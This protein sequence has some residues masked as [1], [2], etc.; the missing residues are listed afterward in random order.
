MH[1]NNYLFEI[2]NLPSSVSVE[3]KHLRLFRYR[4]AAC[5]FSNLGAILL[6]IHKY[7]SQER[8]H[9]LHRYMGVQAAQN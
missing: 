9:Q 7:E 5:D 2:P 6:W 3:E 8:S 1:K 4:L